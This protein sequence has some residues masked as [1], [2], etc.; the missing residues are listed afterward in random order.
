MLKKYSN[1]KLTLDNK[2]IELFLEG[3]TFKGIQ[4]RLGNPSK[5][6]IS[7]VL[8]EQIPEEYLKLKDTKFINNKRK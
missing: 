6:Y 5:K 2:I 1:D 8:K 3:Y 7:T 4:L